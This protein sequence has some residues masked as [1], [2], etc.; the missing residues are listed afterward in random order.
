MTAGAPRPYVH[1]IFGARQ[2]GNSLR[3]RHRNGIIL[4]MKPS[5]ASLRSPGPTAR[6]VR[7]PADLRARIASDALR[8]GR[9]FEAQVLALLRRH[10]GE[11]VDVAPPADALLQLARGSFAGLTAAQQR[12]ITRRLVQR[13]GK[14]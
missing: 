6:T 10:Y 13:D 12:E 8:C 3:R 14:A 1:V 5:R 2:C 7:F 4:V 9:S 11:D